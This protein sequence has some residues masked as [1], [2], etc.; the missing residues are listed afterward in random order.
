[1]KRIII[2]L[3]AISATIFT[4]NAQIQKGNVLIGA[5]L[6]DLYLGLDNSNA[7]RFN[8]TPKAAWFIQDNVALGG[9]VNF[10]I[11]TA[12]NSSTTTQ[13]GIGAFGRYYLEKDVEVLKHGRFFGEANF[14]FAGINV[15]NGGGNTNGIGFGFGPGFAY[16]VTQN[17][18]LEA[19]LKYNG[20]A[21]FGNTTVQSGLTLSLGFQIYLPGKS[22][23]QKVQSDIR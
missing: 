18:G 8:I 14:G 19:L 3:V 1:M 16:F 21:G 15:S 17:I 22:T 4:A 23:A 11:Q 6:S 10:G 13:Y 20:T 5:N 2:T 9:Y 7:F 12:K